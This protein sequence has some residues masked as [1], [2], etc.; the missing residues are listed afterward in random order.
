MNLMD[1]KQAQ[2]SCQAL[3]DEL[4]RVTGRMSQ[5]RL[6]LDVAKR[7]NDPDVKALLNEMDLIQNWALHTA[8]LAA[9]VAKRLKRTRAVKR[10]GR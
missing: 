10:L 6:N 1:D 7:L 2:E 8:D 4:Q 3:A 5:V 9:A